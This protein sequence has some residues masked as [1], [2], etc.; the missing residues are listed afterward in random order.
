MKKRTMIL[1]A[2]GILFLFFIPIMVHG[3]SVEEIIEETEGVTAPFGFSASQ[4][5]RDVLAGKLDISFL[6]VLTKLR[7][8]FFGTLHENLSLT[9]KMTAAGLMSGICMQ[10]PEGEQKIGH[11][12]CILFLSYFALQTFS[13][14]KTVTEGTVDGLFLFV[15]GML[16]AVGMAA[17]T[18]GSVS[19]GG[20][21]VAFVA[22]QVFI[23]LL[24]HFMLPLISVIVILSVTDSLGERSYLAG[25]LSF[26]KQTFKWSTG[27]LL[28]LYG[29]VIGIQTGATAIFDKMAGKTVKYAVSSF[30]PVVGR[31]LADSLDTVTMSAK[32]IRASL[33]VSGIIGV[34]FVVM[35]PVLTLG[36]LALCYKIAGALI[37]V[38][39]EKKTVDFISEIGNGITRLL[40]VLVAVGVM[41]II[42]LAM[43]CFMGGAV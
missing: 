30:V 42:S 10:L 28:V 38:Y 43:L 11:F 35:S 12:A 15:Q 4:T 36:A 41:F 9:V 20:V 31:A 40:G 17:V 33:G 37:S 19:G 21:S 34:G 13:Y 14:A 3:A 7:E 39:G 6:G 16:P 23:Q 18:S 27:L 1:C 32:A 22:M 5:A 25:I 24:R 29:G 8:L 2:A 26:L